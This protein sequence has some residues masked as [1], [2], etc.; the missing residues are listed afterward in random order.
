M[1]RPCKKLRYHGGKTVPVFLFDGTILTPVRELLR[2]FRVDR[3]PPEAYDTTPLFWR[4]SGA[5]FT[6]DYVREVVRFLARRE[7]RIPKVFP[8]AWP[9]PLLPLPLAISFS[10]EAHKADIFGNHCLQLI[11]GR[12]LLITV[13]GPLLPAA[14][15][16]RL[17]CLFL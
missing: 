6:T 11:A 2:L 7:A 13:L 10:V 3:V 14:G 17:C 12:L 9:P 16:R 1:M 15:G 8:T 5:S 4:S